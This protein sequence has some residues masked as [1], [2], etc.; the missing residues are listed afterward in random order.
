MNVLEALSDPGLFGALPSFQDLSTWRAWLAF[1]KAVYG[2]PLDAEELT[3]FQKHTGQAAPHPGGYPEAVAIVG[4]QSGKSA[5]AALVC[6]FEAATGTERGTFAL[7]VAQDERAVKRTLFNY[8]RQPFRA[9]PVLAREVVRETADT[10][11]LASGVSLAC[12]PCRAAAVRGVRASIVAVDELAY[13]TATDGKPTD[14]EMLRA[15]RPCLATTGG[16]LLILSSPYGQSGALWDLHR[17]HY[18]KDDSSTL[19]WQAS[20]P[21]MNPT[22]PADY[23]ARMEADDPE[24]FR[25]EVLGEFRAGLATLFDAEALEA[26]VVPERRELP[27][28]SE[29]LYES[30]TDPSGGR[31][32]SFTVAIGHRDAEDRV[33]VDVLRAWKPPFN[34]SGVV[35]E[36]ASLLLTY[37]VTSV[38]GDRYGGE[39]PRESFRSH[40]IAYDLAEKAKSDL[41]LELLAAV[42]SGTVELPDVPELLRE[43]RGLERRRG[44]SGRDRVDHRPGSH[45]DRANA[46]AGL[47]SVLSASLCEPMVW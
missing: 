18:G 37:N 44:S 34:P 15:L 41:Y 25:S 22:L 38:T 45:D 6:A 20:A 8:A 47:V 12:Y 7:L 36:A 29:L 13:F 28:S 4:R 3:I 16:K 43:L 32:D 17:G 1:L 26:V 23:L 11:D 14:T 21:E 5:V 30:F 9:V 31:S 42:N 27:P 19:I 35:E 39:W 33:I 24:A 10:L 40:G 46:V 2:L